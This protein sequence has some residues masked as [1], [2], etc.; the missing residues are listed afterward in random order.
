MKYCVRCLYP[1]NHPLGI[2]FNEKSVCS[3]CLIHGEKD[4]INWSE[5]EKKLKKILEQ[6]RNKDGKNYDC[7]IPVSGARDSYFIV[8]TVKNVYKMHPLLVTYNK[9]YNT[10]LGIRNL[11]YLKTI[12]GCDLFTLTISPETVKKITRYTIEKMGSVYWHCIAGQTVFPVQ[13]AVRFKIPLII[14]GVH[15]GVDQVGQFS[16]L[17][18]VEMTRRYRKDHDLMGFESEDLIDDNISESDVTPYKY[19]HDKEI[20]K[21]GVRGI[22]LSNYIRWDS[23]KQHELMINLYGYKTVLQ[24]R[25]FD[26]YNDVDCFNYSELHDYIKFLKWGYGKAT[27]HATREIRLKRLTQEK[28]I[29]LVRKYQNLKPSKKALQLF[30]SWISMPEKEFWSYIDKKRDP[31]IWKKN[32]RNQWQLQD[33]VINHAKDEGVDSARLTKK[34]NCQ[35][36]INKREGVGVKEKEDKYVLIGRGWEGD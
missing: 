26:T 29:E 30:L 1:A 5:R 2:I 8:H 12:F 18:E 20:E 21:V 28:G 11:A 13:I 31:E 10:K 3:G 4:V 17:D 34:D 16:H 23:K 36:I 25:T 33:S 7:I 15:Q 22:Y 19:P 9:Q 35:F 32:K 6:Y 27:D 24:P 14:W